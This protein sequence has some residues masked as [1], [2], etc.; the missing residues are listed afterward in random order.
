MLTTCNIATQW[1]VLAK[2]RIDFLAA[3]LVPSSARGPSS[4]SFQ[5]RPS[6]LCAAR[7]RKVISLGLFVML[8]TVTGHHR[9]C[10]RLVS[11][12]LIGCHHCGRRVIGK[13]PHFAHAFRP[14]TDSRPV[15]P[16]ERACHSLWLQCNSGQRENN[17]K[18]DKKK[19]DERTVRVEFR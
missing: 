2:R 8:L 6:R 12:T 5:S 10:Q 4:A 13:R 1:A 19:L 18:F 3:A 7:D 11:Y 14:T 16:I 9:N 15:S 17:R